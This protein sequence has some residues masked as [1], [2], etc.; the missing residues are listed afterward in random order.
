MHYVS[1][2]RD[3]GAGTHLL[4]EGLCSV[5]SQR[6]SHVYPALRKDAKDGAIPR[7]GQMLYRGNRM[8]H[9]SIC[10]GDRGLRENSILR[11]GTTS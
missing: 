9:P 8:G 2:K 5:G 6:V 4:R 11:K 10:E 3:K 7:E 1:D